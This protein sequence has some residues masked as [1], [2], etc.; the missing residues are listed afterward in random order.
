MP[1]ASDDHF[2]VLK[3]KVTKPS[4]PGFKIGATSMSFAGQKGPPISRESG[5]E[6]IFPVRRS[7][8]SSPSKLVTEHT[9]L[10]L[11]WPVNIATTELLS[12]DHCAVRAFSATL[13]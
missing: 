5:I 12:G 3:S 9:L 13:V 8:V 11:P 1:F 10:A 4:L 6:T 2:P 7:I